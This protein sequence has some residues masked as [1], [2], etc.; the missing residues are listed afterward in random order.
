[1]IAGII[2]CSALSIRRSAL[3]KVDPQYPPEVLAQKA[4]DILQRFGYTGRPFGEA[5]EFD[6]EY[7]LVNYIDEH[8]KPFPGWADILA[9][10]P[11]LLRFWYR[12][13]PYA[14]TPLSFHDDL[15]T[16]S[17]PDR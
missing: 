13:S 8:E 1:M 12:Q 6:W 4:K 16:P 3:E 10:R 11:T 7:S 2:L 9:K 14:L 17:D 15:L 5:Y